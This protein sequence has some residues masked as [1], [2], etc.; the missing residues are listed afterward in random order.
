MTLIKSNLIEGI[1]VGLYTIYNNKIKIVDNR[2]SDN[3]DNRELF[4]VTRAKHVFS[5]QNQAYKNANNNETEMLLSYG[6]EVL[7]KPCRLR[8]QEPD[9]TYGP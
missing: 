8:Q 9:T 2:N 3:H 1:K 7:N 4:T 6:L 5:D